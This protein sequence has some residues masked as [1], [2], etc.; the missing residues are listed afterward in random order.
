MKSTWPHLLLCY[1]FKF[2]TLKKSLFFFFL[3]DKKS[4]WEV[5]YWSCF[6]FLAKVSHENTAPVL[7]LLD[8]FLACFSFVNNGTIK[9]MTENNSKKD[10]LPTHGV[11]TQYGNVQLADYMFHGHHAE[12]KCHCKNMCLIVVAS[13]SK[14]I[15]NK[16]LT[17]CQPESDRPEESVDI[18]WDFL[19][20]W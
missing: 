12:A 1:I 5:P 8:L 13:R 16:S 14:K 18:S 11:C 10:I 20:R 15:W 17:V 7:L 2:S 6:F 4:Y 9:I 19:S 3:W